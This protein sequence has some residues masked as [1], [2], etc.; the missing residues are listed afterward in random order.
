L[1]SLGVALSIA[2][3]IDEFRPSSMVETCSFVTALVLLIYERRAARQAMRRIAI[4]HATEELLMNAKV[5]LDGSLMTDG[6]ELARQLK[7]LRWGLRHY[8]PTLS[9]GA[10]KAAL[11]GGALDGA[12][13]AS[14]VEHL[15]EWLA[16]AELC[17]ARF[18]M[19]ELLLFFL[20]ATSS[21][22]EE[23]LYLHVSI[24]KGPASKQR[25][26]LKR[27]ADHLEEIVAQGL[28]PKE[29]GEHLDEMLEAI[30]EFA[31]AEAVLEEAVALAES[32]GV[33]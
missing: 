15:N 18:A 3:A 30:T 33:V 7:D 4:R 19:A 24:A 2:T 5:L 13:D 9:T 11:T 14:L 22:M 32:I 21:G 20:P 28:L 29:S 8:Y 10:V 23:R 25:E 12:R 26:A 1:V 27:T 6:N 17:N 31:R 16:E